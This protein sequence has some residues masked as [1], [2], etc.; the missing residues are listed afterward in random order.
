[1]R[2]SQPASCASAM[3]AP[4]LV[5]S[6]RGP[7]FA[8]GAPSASRCDRS[9]VRDY[10]QR[11]A[12]R[13][14]A[15]RWRESGERGAG[16]R[17]LTRQPRLAPAR[18]SS[19]SVSETGCVQMSDLKTEAKEATEAKT[20]AAATEEPAKENMMTKVRMCAAATQG[21]VTFVAPPAATQRHEERSAQQGKGSVAGWISGA[22]QLRHGTNAPKQAV[23][24]AR[25][26]EGAHA[27]SAPCCE[28]PG[29]CSRP[30]PDRRLRP[31][32]RISSPPLWH[33]LLGS[34]LPP[35]FGCTPAWFPT[36]THA[37]AH[38][39]RRSRLRAWPAWCHMRCG[40]SRSG[41]F[42]CL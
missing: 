20:D 35:V 27:Y 28:A 30:L 24:R 40:S 16:A 34:A 7:R 4:A 3:L 29:T 26:S 37:C 1:M 21:A 10:W 14:G 31:F 25:Q 39:P 17:V 38:V 22:P 36:C 8:W 23:G 13:T 6:P 33:S 18:G 19:L 9:S 5:R 2:R 12:A 41:L 11:G 42:P 32:R 15:A